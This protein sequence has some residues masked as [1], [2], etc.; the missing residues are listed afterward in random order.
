[1]A[2]RL[3]MPWTALHV[4]GTGLESDPERLERNLDLARSLGAEVLSVPDDDVAAAIVRYA[5]IKKASTLII[6]KTETGTVPLIG[7]RS[8][9]ESVLREAGE[10]DLIVLRGKNPVPFQQ[11]FPGLPYWFKSIKGVPLAILVLFGVTV[12][13]LAAMPVLGY[14]GISILYLLAIKIGRASC[15][16]TV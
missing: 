14:R 12:F 13:G 5:R 11:H 4:R 1:M 10:L 8:V 9:M 2:R 3:S 6:G 16:E 7:R 15:R